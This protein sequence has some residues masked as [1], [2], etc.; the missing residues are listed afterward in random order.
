M[1]PRAAQLAQAVEVAEQRHVGV[2]GVRRV[3]VAAG[4]AVGALGGAHQGEPGLAHQ[5]LRIA[6]L[7]GDAEIE[8]GGGLGERDGAGEEGIAPV[9]PGGGKISR[10]GRREEGLDLVLGAAHGG[11]RGD[12][13][14]LTARPSGVCRVRTH[15]ASMA[16]S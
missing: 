5:D 13:L 3:P 4:V 8:A 1:P 14:R 11:G 9:G 7:G 2:G 6:A 15:R 12:D 10:P 16:V